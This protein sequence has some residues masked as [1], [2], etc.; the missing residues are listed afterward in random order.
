MSKMKKSELK[1]QGKGFFG[2]FK[3]FIMRGNVIDLAVGV[4]IG[5][6]FQAIVNSLVND[7]ISPLL[8]VFTKGINFSDKFI[9]LGFTEEHFKTAAQAA[10]AGYA[11]FNYGSLITAIINFLIMSFV[12]FLIVK[13]INK[14]ASLGKKDEK[15]QEAQEP[16]TKVC[17]FCKSEISIEATRCPHCTSQLDEEAE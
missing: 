9:V 11:T 15:S 2:E 1:K 4:I 3:T 8:S 17:P 6:A 14:I 7:L 13:G 5:G 16:T 12:I 10:E